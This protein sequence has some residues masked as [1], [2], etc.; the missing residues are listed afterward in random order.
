MKRSASVI[1]G[2]YKKKVYLLI[3]TP[4]YIKPGAVSK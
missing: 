2:V 3:S 4:G 1:E